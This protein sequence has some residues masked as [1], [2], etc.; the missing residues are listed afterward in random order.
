M[1]KKKD[2][3]KIIL[4]QWV[5]VF[6]LLAVIAIMVTSIFS[7]VKA[8][9][10]E[11]VS[12]KKLYDYNYN[13]GMNYKVYLKKNNFFTAPYLDMN[14]QYIA[15]IIDH[16]EVETKYD[17]KSS[18]ELDYNYNYS[19]VATAR[20]LGEDSEGKKVDVWSKEYQ[21]APLETNSGTGKNFNIAKTINIDYNAYNQVL[22]DFRTQFGLSVDARVDVTL[23]LNITAGLK[24]SAEKTLQDSSEMSLQIPL[25][26]QMVRIKPDYMNTGGDTIY[27]SITPENKINIPLVAIWTVVLII[28]LIVFVK[29][30]KSLLAVTRKSEYIL[31]VNKIMKEYGDII[32]ETHNMPDLNKYD[33]VNIKS[34]T[35]MV[36]IEEELHSPI[37]YFEIEENSKCVFLILN[38][39]TAYRF[40]LKE[41]E[42]DHFGNSNDKE[43]YHNQII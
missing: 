26:V 15:S 43:D 42:F 4:K 16:I 21:L 40:L 32:A 19:I 13:A 6:L 8:V 10:P 30:V 37:I 22:T 1:K 34:F 28:S 29:L 35:D 12:K 33:I 7:I 41:S 3:N 5:R 11:A 17:F 9:K 31:A 24:G 18:E 27:G 25:L 38:D 36:D 23:K 20:G 14:R 39:K 2:E